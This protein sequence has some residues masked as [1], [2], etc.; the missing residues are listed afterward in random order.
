[1][2]GHLYSVADLV[3][4]FNAV[5]RP[6]ARRSDGSRWT[7]HNVPVFLEAAG[8]K[9]LPHKRG[10]KLYYP[11]SELREQMP[12][13]WAALEEAEHRAA[14]ARELEDAGSADDDAFDLALG[15]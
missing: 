15:R 6:E 4:R 8:V 11:E 1:L 10:G 9:P 5:Q 13:F 2:P 7:R 14:I 3:D 12:R